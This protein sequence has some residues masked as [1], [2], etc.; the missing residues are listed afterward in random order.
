MLR[1]FMF[2]IDFFFEYDKL[3]IFFFVLLCLELIFVWILCDFGNIDLMVVVW[4]DFVFGMFLFLLCFLFGFDLIFFL[5]EGFLIVVICLIEVVF[6]VLLIEILDFFGNE[7]DFCLLIWLL[8]LIREWF[9]LFL[10]IYFICWLDLCFV[11][12]FL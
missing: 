3:L 9:F 5:V 8:D 2:E 1:M 7:N 6:F 11:L 12:L 4:Y 10:S